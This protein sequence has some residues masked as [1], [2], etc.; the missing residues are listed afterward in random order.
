V[1]VHGG[2]GSILTALGHGRVPV[3]LARSAALGEHVDDH[4]ERM[5]ESLAERGLIVLVRP[6]EVLEKR[7][8]ERAAGMVSRRCWM[9]G[10]SATAAELRAP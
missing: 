6:D 5:C 3:V 1:I 8:L 7:H 10:S 2:A 4:Q 9:S